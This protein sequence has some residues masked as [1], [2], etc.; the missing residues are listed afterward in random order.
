MRP[1]KGVKLRKKAR[2]NLYYLLLLLWCEETNDIK[3][4]TQQEQMCSD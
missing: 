3:T 1:K 2:P 4:E